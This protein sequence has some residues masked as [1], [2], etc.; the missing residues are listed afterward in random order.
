MNVEFLGTAARSMRAHHATVARVGAGPML[1]RMRAVGAVHPLR[2]GSVV[3]PH[4]GV[5]GR[6]GTGARHDVRVDIVCDGLN[7]VFR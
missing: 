7:V 1:Q 6:E 2:T 3:S 4:A 5:R